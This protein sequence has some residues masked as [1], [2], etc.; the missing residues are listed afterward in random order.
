MLLKDSLGGNSKTVMFAN[1]NPSAN[2]VSETIST[3]RFADRAKQIKNKPVVNMDTKD[4]KIAELTEMVNELRTKLE[5]YSTG[6]TLGL[7]EEV[8]QLREKVGELEVN[9]DNAVKSREADL[10][11]FENSKQQIIE[12]R[13][14]FNSRL[15]EMEE[16]VSQL[17]NDLQIA[18]TNAKDAQSSL[19][20]VLQLC[21]QY[22]NDKKPIATVDELSAILKDKSFGGNSAES[23]QLKTQVETLT[24]ENKSL[25]K[26]YKALKKD[27]EQQ[28]KNAKEEAQAAE[29]KMKRMKKELQASHDAWEVEAESDAAADGGEAKERKEEPNPQKA[30][31]AL[32]DDYSR[33]QDELI[34]AMK[35]DDNGATAIKALKKENEEL[36][37]QLLAKPSAIAGAGDS[38]SGAEVEEI[39]KSLQDVQKERDGLYE[40]LSAAREEAAEAAKAAAEANGKINEVRGEYERKLATASSSAGEVDKLTAKLKDRNDQL[41]QMRTLLDKQKALIVK[42]NEK[43]EYYQQEVKE[44]NKK[45]ASTEERYR[46]MLDEKDAQFQKAVS[47]RLEEYMTQRKEEEKDRN[48]IVKKLKKKI[49]KMQ[50]NIA[51]LEQNFD[52]KVCECEELRELLSEQKL[53]QM[54]L[55]RRIDS[56]ANNANTSAD[57]ELEVEET[58][59][60]IQNALERAKEERK[61]KSDMFAM[62][63]VK[64]AKNK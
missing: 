29:S 34:A 56:T 28:L 4:Q 44:A 46:A 32:N 41:E 31:K 5:K 51:E 11:D 30:I 3:L 13:Q 16:Q 10:V 23:S 22:L 8:E 42:S 12:E 19:E 59:E 40:Q 17:Q 58:K 43:A 64:N 54:K 38:T 21:A 49:T 45:T 14:T 7:E 53:Q 35:V 6:G 61:R 39:R 57:E 36:R 63:E 50:D 60:K 2:N 1:I 26:D 25:K 24:V 52:M 18:E 37:Q 9:L 33:R 55:V 20:E 15:V 27:M 47:E 62:G 48:T